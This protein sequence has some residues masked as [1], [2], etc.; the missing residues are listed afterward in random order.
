MD[1]QNQLDTIE[2]PL[3]VPEDEMIINDLETLKAVSDPFRLS[4]LELLSEPRTVK[5]IAPKLKVGKTKLYYHINVLEK[6]G[7]IRVVRKRF[8]SGILEKSYQI[9]AMRFRP[10]P[11]LLQGSEDGDAR[12]QAIF[13]SIFDATRTDF[14]RSAKSGQFDDSVEKNE[15][16]LFIGRTLLCLTEAQAR[17]F[18]DR[19]DAMME[20]FKEYEI[21]TP[22]STP[23]VLTIAFFPKA[24][25]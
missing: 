10:A 11:E 25:E 24:K 17:S 4:I 23:Y 19:F 8:V 18:S 1:N 2:E 13:D 16:K 22:D 21:N 12:R 3:P 6:H 5:E 7:V 14:I 20:E 15:K 9:A